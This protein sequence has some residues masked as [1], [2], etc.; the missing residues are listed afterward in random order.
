MTTATC[1]D[2]Y[3]CISDMGVTM[4]LASDPAL[5]AESTI[6]TSHDLDVANVGIIR[7]NEFVSCKSR[8]F[9]CQLQ[10]Q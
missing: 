1:L 8:H 10:L 9:N 2:H 7:G 5:H 6:Y 3:A 4:L